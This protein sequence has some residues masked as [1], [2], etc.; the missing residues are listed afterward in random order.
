MKSKTIGLLVAGFVLLH[1][2]ATL[3][4]FWAEAS[5]ANYAMAHYYQQVHRYPRA[6]M[7]IGHQL[8]WFPAG[9]F[10][11]LIWA[12]PFYGILR[13]ATWAIGRNQRAAENVVARA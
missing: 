10:S 11:S 8:L 2:C 12:V 7:C 6:W 5:S 13:S 3:F 4:C 1:F 9:P